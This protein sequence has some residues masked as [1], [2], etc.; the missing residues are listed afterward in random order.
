M[1]QSA[2]HRIQGHGRGNVLTISVIRVCAERV[3]EE[4]R[5]GKGF[6]GRNLDGLRVHG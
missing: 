1:C 4:E 6:R 3:A 5:V 2:C